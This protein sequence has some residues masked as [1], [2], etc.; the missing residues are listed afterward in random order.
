MKSLFKNSVIVILL[1]G[2]TIYF[3]SCNEEATP[4]VVT[5]SV[6][7]DITFTSA[8]TGG[9]VKDEGGAEVTEMG[10][11][12]STRFPTVVDSK[13]IEGSGSGSFTS[14]ITGLMPGTVYYVRAY[15]VNSAGTAYGKMQMF[16]TAIQTAGTLK[17]NFPGGERYGA[18]SF[19][20]G[21]KVYSGLGWL[22]TNGGSTGMR[23][24]WEWDQATDI[25]TKKADYPGNS[26]SGAVGF[27][28]G[29]KGYIGTGNS[30][31]GEN[32]NEFWEFDPATNKW[33][34]KASLPLD[35]ARSSA[36]GF[37]I[38]TKG[39]IGTGTGG[40][41]DGWEGNYYHLNDF[42]EWDQATNVWTRKADLE[43]SGRSNAVGFSIGTKGYIGTGIGWVEEGWDGDYLLDFWEWDQATNVWK[44]KAD[45]EKSGRS[46][47]VGFSIG[48]KGYLATGRS[49]SSI[50]N[51]DIWEWD[52]ATDVWIKK[53]LLAGTSRISAFGVSIGDKGYIGT[54]YIN[55]YINEFEDEIFFLNDFWEFDPEELIV[56]P[57][58]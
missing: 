24:F 41:G 48:N 52:Q 55:D 2:T 49:S 28:I 15:A 43:G 22:G 26:V 21:T 35:A 1:S 8:S 39:Y 3:T 11:C 25:W 31:T 58:R 44:R 54:G 29:S 38:G 4:P 32:T 27:S 13:T 5:T 7:S 19:A 56:L 16:T 53:A 6:I 18:V 9:V 45:F 42:W 23:D 40:G 10:V 20:V 37:S 34:E 47:A 46:G 51:K 50:F 57:D 33:T 30:I 36:V 17:A 14:I 12:W